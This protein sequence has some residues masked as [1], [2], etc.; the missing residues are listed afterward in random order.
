MELRFD[1]K[2][3]LSAYAHLR[4]I[5]DST[6]VVYY[7]TL[8]SG[9]RTI[10]VLVKCEHVNSMHTFK[11]RGAEIAVSQ[12]ARSLLGQGQDLSNLEIVTASAGNHA[13]GVALAASRWKIPAKIFMPVDTPEPK[14]RRIE[15]A[16]KAA[17]DGL[18]SIVKTGRDFDET[19]E[20]ALGYKVE[21][22][23]T[24]LG[25]GQHKRVFVPPYQNKE[26]IRGQGSILVEY[27]VTNARGIDDR[28]ALRILR[29]EERSLN[30]K[31]YFSVP[32][33]VVASLGGGGLV[34]GL[35]VTARY[36]NK[37]L[38]SDIKVVGV[39]SELADAMYRSYH[40]GQ[41][42]PSFKEGKTIADG[43]AVK[44]ASEEM[45]YLVKEFV[46][47]VLCVEEEEILQ[48]IRKF[49]YHPKVHGKEFS[50][51]ERYSPKYPQRTLPG[52]QQTY[53][54]GR[55]LDRIEGAAAAAL[56][57]V[58]HLDYKTLGLENKEHLTV[59]VILSGGNIAE[60]TFQKIIAK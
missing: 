41:L 23:G 3:V 34:S 49:H 22:N 13:Q 8:Q 56:A 30:P 33:V 51:V 53:S 17:P 26:I 31:E 21:T 43:I 16:I 45:L 54:H 20:S 9:G 48:T 47:D 60:D 7:Q 27:V 40:A 29:R 4:E 25:Q 35:G 11:V 5:F 2:E 19:L 36:L 52:S 24:R 18:I 1:G 57:G 59:L 55:P 39:Q 58:P 44:K 12:T 32:D 46:D 50:A 15:D 28:V 10:D 14:I 37:L 6:P 38:D 42:L